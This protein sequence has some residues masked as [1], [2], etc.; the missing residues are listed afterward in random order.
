[1]SVLLLPAISST[2]AAAE[3]LRYN[4]FEQPAIVT[5]SNGLHAKNATGGVMELRGTLVDGNTSLANIGGKHYRLN[6]EVS[7]YRV[8]R[9]SSGSVTLRAGENEIELTLQNEK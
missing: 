4:P 9:I 6:E 3:L 2:A 1:M 7:G 5:G 8:T